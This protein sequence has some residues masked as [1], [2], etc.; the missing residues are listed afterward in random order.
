MPELPEVETVRAGLAR[1]LVGRRFLAV[2]GRPVALRSLLDPAAL[3]RLMVGR[4]VRAVRRRAKYLLI[5]LAAAAPAQEA[6][7]TVLVHLGMSGRLSWQRQGSARRPHDHLVAEADGGYELCYYDPRRFGLLE[8]LGPGEESGHRRLA[9]LGREPLGPPVVDG[10][11]VHQASRGVRA[12]VKSWL[13]DARVLVGVGNIYACEAL[14]AAGIHP[15]RRAGSLST[16][17]ADRLAQAVVQ[18]L[19][20]AI[21]Q[22]G[23]TL[24]DFA[25]AEGQGGL[26][27]PQLAAYGRH[28]LGCARCRRPIARRVLAGRGTF[29][30]PGCQH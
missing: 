3:A 18:V 1:C 17:R 14:W 29:Y 5:D 27:L 12:P 15:W 26:F 22:G 11:F 16:R 2:A 28:R 19:T 30:C 13:M 24:R 21:A 6:C 20:A 4:R 25:N 7:G 9:G 10:A 23:T 8:P